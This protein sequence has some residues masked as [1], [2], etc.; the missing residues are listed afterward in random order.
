[1][2]GP[3]LT[4]TEAVIHHLSLQEAE[5]FYDGFPAVIDKGS[6]IHVIRAGS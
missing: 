6:D 1:M 4:W 3:P 2:M 5:G